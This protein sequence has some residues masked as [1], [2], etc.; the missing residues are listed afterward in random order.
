MAAVRRG[1]A[2]NTL[3]NNNYGTLEERLRALAEPA[4]DDVEAAGK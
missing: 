1:L 3:V 4:V 2:R